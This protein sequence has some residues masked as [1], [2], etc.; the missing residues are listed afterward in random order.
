[1][2]TYLSILLFIL[3]VTLPV[4]H[5]INCLPFFSKKYKRYLQN[6]VKVFKGLSII[7]P[8][9]NEENVINTAI[10]GM[11]RIE[12][13]NKEV[14]Y[15]NDGSTD[16]TFTLLTNLL[17]LRHLYIRPARK[18][19]Y[20]EVEGFYFSNKFK[21]TY[22]INKRNG[23]KADALN[24]GIDY[25]TKEVV[26][27]LDA[28][29]ILD[30]KALDVINQVF[31]DE[32]VIAAG[33]MVH[34]LQGKEF[35]TGTHVRQNMKLKNI[36]RLQMLEYLKG[37]YINKYSLAKSKALAIISGAFGVFDKEIL[38]N[39]GGYRH[40]VG[41]DIDITLRFQRY[42]FEHKDKKMVF[43]PEAICY[44]ECPENWSDLFKQRVRWQKAFIDC[45]FKYHKMLIGTFLVRRVSFFFLL[46]AFI[47]GTASIFVAVYWSGVFLVDSYFGNIPYVLLL[48]SLT[49]NLTYNVIAIFLA[50]H[51]GTKFHKTD[52]SRL[53]LTV[54]LDSFVFR[55]I[56][57]FYT[58]FGTLTYFV[59][60]KDWNK[61]KRTGRLYNFEKVIQVD[62]I[63][64]VNA[65]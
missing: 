46:D 36:I 60:K 13:E 56:I 26:I 27:T 30:T 65:D 58:L 31:Q 48:A 29:S 20:K 64:E 2:I 32:N 47:V 12:Y 35:E 16:E 59:N 21:N 25:S 50:K 40:T 11:Q 49:M 6:E 15:V 8:C 39:V 45:I 37:F 9:Y 3:C 55:F 38:F 34:V 57:M 17:D 51:Y 62:K 61:V 5:L 52:K 24:S 1:M 22:V 28:D 63:I 41:E 18:L 54:L 42:I 19:K 14:I 10:S 43:A 7:I 53:L 23:G 33:G 44:T 4:F